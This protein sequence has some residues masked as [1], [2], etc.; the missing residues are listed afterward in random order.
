MI[1]LDDYQENTKREQTNSRQLNLYPRKDID[2]A[3]YLL[4][5]CVT[6]LVCVC[7]LVNTSIYNARM[8]IWDGQFEC[9]CARTG[10]SREWD[11]WR[12]CSTWCGRCEFSCIQFKLQL[13]RAVGVF[14][15][16]EY[17]DDL[18]VQIEVVR[19]L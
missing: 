17:R 19:K 10:V 16:D 6:W 7:V 5:L 9:K 2:V 8:C 4:A 15:N 3:S 1:R 18:C 12:L 11:G 14:N 13:I